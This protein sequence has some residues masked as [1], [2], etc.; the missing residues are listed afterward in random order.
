MIFTKHWDLYK[1][2]VRKSK[3]LEKM[4]EHEWKDLDMH[5]VSVIMMSLPDIV[6]FNIINDGIAIGLWKK[7]ERSYLGRSLTTKLD[8]QPEDV[9][10]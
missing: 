5:M 9:R 3:K 7:L 10:R 2:L 6:A 1:A 8:V 4:T